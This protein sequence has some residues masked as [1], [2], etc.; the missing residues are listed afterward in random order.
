MPIF[1]HDGLLY[2]VHEP[3]LLL[4]QVSLAISDGLSK[5]TVIEIFDHL[6]QLNVSFSEETGCTQTPPIAPKR[7]LVA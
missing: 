6:T 3:A 1:Q 2:I 5:V 4:G 7:V